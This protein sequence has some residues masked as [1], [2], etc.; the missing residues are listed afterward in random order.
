MAGLK[1]EGEVANPGSLGFAELAALPQ[2]IE[3]IAALVPG[4]SGGAVELA[5]ILTAVGVSDEATHITLASTDGDFAAS[6]PLTAVA[7]AIVVYRDGVSAL[8]VSA[9]GPVRF[10]IP[11]VGDCHS[12]PVDAC[13]NVKFLGTIRLTVG[14]GRDTRP[15]NPTEHADLHRHE[16]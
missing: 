7:S 15:T 12:G 11:E 10:F 8:P 9:G 3:D 6:V 1:V 14:P 5:A 16:S 13:V 4:R 2:Q